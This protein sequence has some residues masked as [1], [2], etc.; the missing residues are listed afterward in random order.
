MADLY[1]ICEGPQNGL[2]VR[3][4]DRIIAQKLGK[5]VLINGAGGDTSLG[6]VATFL[7]ERS[8]KASPDGV[9]ATAVDRAYSVEDRNFSSAEIV[10]SKW[11]LA[12]KRFVWRRHEIENY[13]LDP[14]VV[15]NAFVSLNETLP[16]A[17]PDLPQTPEEIRA[18]LETAARPMIEDH[19]GW[20]VHAQLNERKNVGLNTRIKGPPGSSRAS[21]DSRYL[22]RQAWL[23]HLSTECTRIK[24]ECS[25][26]S[27]TS[28]FEESAI[29]ELYDQKLGEVSQPTFFSSDRYL[30]DMS[31]K[32]LMLA[33][34]QYARQHSLP[35]LTRSVLEVELIDALDRV[36]LPNYFTRDDFLE[37][38]NRLV[39][40][41]HHE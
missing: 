33:L 23:G 9:L 11:G 7:E 39:E 12:S 35:R 1:L 27:A 36:Y 26:F 22:N 6:S 19:A 37:L 8:R 24:Q 21:A 31:G 2:D 40:P 16:D 41:G 4:L 38:A 25:T 10:E 3:V 32:D 34:L 30:A 20:L 28:E 29:T 14:G 18:V 5:A 13:L 15:A 17:V